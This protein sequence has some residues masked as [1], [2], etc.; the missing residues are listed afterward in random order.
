MRALMIAIALLMAACA[1]STSDL[2]KEAH[3]TGDWEA[4]NH[5]LAA[6]DLREN[7]SSACGDGLIMMCTSRCECVSNQ[8]A[9]YRVNQMSGNPF[10]GSAN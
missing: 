1:S 8:V 9:R 3:E 7:V 5:R 6:E 2:I 4:V 10:G